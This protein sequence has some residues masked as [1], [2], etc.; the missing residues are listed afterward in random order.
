MM[1]VVLEN[2]EVLNVKTYED[3]EDLYEAIEQRKD[4]IFL[5]DLGVYINMHKILY[6]TN[7]IE[8]K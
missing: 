6:I 5:Y 4:W 3:R 2:K 8:E 7:K 1:Q